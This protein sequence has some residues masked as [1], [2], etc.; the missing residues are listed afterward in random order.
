MDEYTV[1]FSGSVGVEAE[2]AEEAKQK[3]REAVNHPVQ[4]EIHGFEAENLHDRPQRFQAKLVRTGSS[5]RNSTT[6]VMT[7]KSALTVGFDAVNAM[8]KAM[9]GKDD[10]PNLKYDLACLLLASLEGDDVSEDAIWNNVQHLDDH[11]KDDGWD[12]MEEHLWTVV[13]E[14]DGDADA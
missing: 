14:D 10:R 7:G 12:W 11:V 4:G 1:H 2:S 6:R 5:M 9:V 13:D 3:A 8:V